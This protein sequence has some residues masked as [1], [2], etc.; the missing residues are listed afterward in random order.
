MTRG[1]E[2]SFW[3]FVSR[4]EL[5]CRASGFTYIVKLKV[6]AAMTSAKEA[7]LSSI[8]ER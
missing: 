6:P 5:E 7:K 8:V 3:V 4:G 2:E 1:L